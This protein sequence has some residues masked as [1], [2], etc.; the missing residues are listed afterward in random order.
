MKRPIIITAVMAFACLVRLNL[1]SNYIITV[2]I[3]LIASLIGTF[4]THYSNRFRKVRWLSAS[5]IS[6]A[7]LCLVFSIYETNYTE[8]TSYIDYTVEIEGSVVDYP[9][10]SV[11]SDYYSCQ[12]SIDTIDGNEVFGK[13][14]L[15]FKDYDTM[16]NLKAG[17]TISFTTTPTEVFSTSVTMTGYYKSQGCYLSSFSMSNVEVMESQNSY[18][19]LIVIK[20]L[21]Y[22]I[23]QTFISDFD[24]DNAGVLISLLFGDKSQLSDEVY[25]WFVYSGLAH[26]MAVSGLHMSIWV[27]FIMEILRKLRAV[28][29]GTN[30]FMLFVVTLVMAFAGFTPS[31]VRAGIMLYIYILAQ[32][33][34]LD[35]N[36]ENSLFLAA[37]LILFINPY[38]A[39]DIR[40]L[41]S[42]GSTF[43]ILYFAVPLIM[44]LSFYINDINL[45]I[46][47][48]NILVLVSSSIIITISTT[49]FTMPLSLLSFGG[50]SLI[51]AISNLI[52]LV[53]LTPMILLAGLYY[54]TAGLPYIGSLINI[55]LENLT[56]VSINIVEK[57][58]SY[59]Y[60]YITPDSIGITIAII[61]SLS[62]IM[63]AVLH[64][65][66]WLQD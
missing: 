32:I 22:N 63:I 13:I 55:S 56:N 52:F 48:K 64:R 6:L 45:F 1:S 59:T 53:F 36:K 8:V 42:F 25:E 21:R 27:L 23:K 3:I 11:D 5:F 62:L 40:F 12:I 35:S 28:S 15:Y 33:F 24:S 17:E 18:N 9:S 10:K 57:L 47:L 2:A 41:F 49:I 7:F 66:K 16:Q 44:K 65:L 61:W 39:L 30:I 34:K 4:V 51:G 50:V 43:A 14:I 29:L 20:N 37:F 54:A 19:P 31:V 58:S 60:A 26:A 38:S 46:T